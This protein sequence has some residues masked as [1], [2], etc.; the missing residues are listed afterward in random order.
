[1]SE[2]DTELQRLKDSAKHLAGGQ[3]RMERA[4]RLDLAIGQRLLLRFGWGDEKVATE[5]PCELLGYSHYEYMI[6]RL[7]PVP[8]LLARLTP[9]ALITA[10]FLYDGGA[11][12][13][14]AEILTHITRPS[15]I[16]FLSYPGSLNTVKIRQHKRLTCALPVSVDT[17][18]G[19][20]IG[21]ISDISKGGCRMVMDIRG[22]SAA[23]ALQ[24]GDQVVVQAMLSACGEPES[25]NAIV[26]NVDQEQFRLVL[27]LAFSNLDAD[28][29]ERLERFLSE[30]LLLL[31]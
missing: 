26:K 28:C 5:I 29:A 15:L 4:S 2:H 14:Q 27:G 20:A 7:Q 8:G 19:T 11:A 24:S 13:F 31:S 16:L 23:R 17:S 12:S 22:Q 9:G 6:V 1:M 3:Q 25:I 21:I 18:N 30:T 10:R